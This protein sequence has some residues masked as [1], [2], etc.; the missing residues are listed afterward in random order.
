M[1]L[2]G[3]ITDWNDAQ[4]FGFVVPNG[5]GD[6]AF[7]HIKAFQRGS[8]RPAIGDLI[9]YL[10]SSDARG[11]LQATEIRHAGQPIE[12]PRA[13]PARGLSAVIGVG[14]LLVVVL[15]AVLRVVPL[16][17]A[18]GIAGLSLWCF[19]VYGLDKR[20]ARHGNPRVSE[21]RLHLLSLVGGWPGALIAQSVFRHKTIKQPFQTVFWTTVVLN[22]VGLAWLVGSGNLARMLGG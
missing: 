4:G 10:P 14:A 16:M 15:L 3:R 9:S 2:A 18:G 6:R 20:A 11:R 13:P 12:T 5:G 22:V 17:M 8:R 7:V 19:V 21:R 1:R